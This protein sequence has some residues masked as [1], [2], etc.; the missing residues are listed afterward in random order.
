[1]NGEFLIRKAKDALQEPARVYTV[2]SMREA[3][4]KRKWPLLRIAARVWLVVVIMTLSYPSHEH[5]CH[6]N[7]LR[8]KIRRYLRDTRGLDQRTAQEWAEEIDYDWIANV[9][10]VGTTFA[11]SSK[12]P[13]AMIGG[14]AVAVA[15]R[16]RIFVYLMYK[17]HK[18]I[19]III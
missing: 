10:T 2:R 7:F 5:A 3:N 14:I 18:A 6:Q 1:M 11:V 8:T 19:G 16:V 17:I 12:N 15:N 4:Q 13:Y 9:M